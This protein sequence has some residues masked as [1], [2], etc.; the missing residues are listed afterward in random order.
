MTSSRNSDWPGQPLPAIDGPWTTFA[1]TASPMAK[2]EDNLSSIVDPA[3]KRAELSGN[4]PRIELRQLRYFLAVAEELNFT[5]AAERMGIAQ[6]PLSQQILNLEQQLKVKLLIRGN[7]QVSLTPEG[8]AFILHARRIINN[9]QMAAEQLVAIRDGEEG[10]LEIGAVFSSLYT[11]IPTLLETF[12]ERYPKVKFHL[13]ELTVGQQLSALREDR[14]D[15]GILRG[16]V[17]Y[18]E[19]ETATIF[20]EPFVTVMS[21]KHSLAKEN[22]LDI[23]QIMREPLISLAATSSLNYR[24]Q[25]F[26]ALSNHMADLRIAH[27]VSDTHTLLGLVAAGMGISLVPASFS[28]IFTD[29]LVYRPLIGS[30]PKTT[31]QL[32]WRRE[33]LTHTL[34]HLVSVVKSIDF[35]SREG[36]DR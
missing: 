25:M 30:T 21:R 8:E 34:G 7:R 13:Q 28:S 27:E 18:E 36:R 2:T 35:G 32:A 6:P 23:Q 15:V 5:R 16:P 20:E 24:R 14:I 10:S 22:A 31:L 9:T 33:S 26:G 4:L 1:E 19:I 12:V 11:I 29:Q 3:S 17:A